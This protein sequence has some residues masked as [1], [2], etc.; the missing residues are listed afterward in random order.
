[1][2]PQLAEALIMRVGWRGAYAT[3][4]LLTLAVAFPVVAIFI[5]EPRP[6][7][8]EHPRPAGATAAAL[9]GLT[10]RQAAATRRFRILLVMLF[11]VAIAIN[12]PVGHIVPLLTDK[13]L[14]PTRAAAMMGLF[15]LATMG[16]R[17]LAGYLVDRFFAAHVATVLCLA[18]SPA[19]FF[20][21]AV[22]DSCPRSA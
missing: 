7:E 3:L 8:G 11:L 18:R 16:G 14:S 22:P 20:S 2:M 19:L 21:R 13:G 5:R 10:A 9:P 1:V 6:G 15:G 4:A 17:L 12:G